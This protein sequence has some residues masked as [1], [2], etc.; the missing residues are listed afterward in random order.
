MKYSGTT[1]TL[2]QEDDEKIRNRISDLATVTET[3][4]AIFPT[5]ITTYGLVENGYSSNIQSVITL[6]DLFV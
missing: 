6:D 3:K 2:K 5:L 1:Y 4:H